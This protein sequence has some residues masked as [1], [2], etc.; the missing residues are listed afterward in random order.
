[1]DA[2]LANKSVFLLI[3]GTASDDAIPSI[4]NVI[5]HL[6]RRFHMNYMGLATN[7][8][9]AAKFYKLMVNKKERG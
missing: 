3:Q 9:E 7:F 6:C 2:P 8:K 4:T 1:L 5:Q